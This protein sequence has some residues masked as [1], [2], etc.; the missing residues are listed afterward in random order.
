MQHTAGDSREELVG[1][2]GEREREEG[3][4][5]SRMKGCDAPHTRKMVVGV[6]K[7]GTNTPKARQQMGTGVNLM[8]CWGWDFAKHNAIC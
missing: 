5:V 1:V 2:V 6:G 4:R 7:S 3:K 8:E